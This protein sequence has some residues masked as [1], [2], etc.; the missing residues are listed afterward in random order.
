MEKFKF[1][2]LKG[3]SVEGDPTATDTTNAIETLT[4]EFYAEDVLSANRFADSIFKLWNQHEGVSL[5]A[6]K[7]IKTAVMYAH[8]YE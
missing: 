1:G 7:Y 3:K 4:C 2:I 6:G 8:L 5:G